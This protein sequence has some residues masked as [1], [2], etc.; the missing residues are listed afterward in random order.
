VETGGGDAARPGADVPV[1][2][3]GVLLL[4]GSTALYR[5]SRRDR[6]SRLR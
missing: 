2:A 3:L 6:G 1:L 4:L 5:S